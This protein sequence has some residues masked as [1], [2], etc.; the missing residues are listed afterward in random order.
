MRC[1]EHFCGQTLWIFSCGIRIFQY[2]LFPSINTVAS[3]LNHS[4]QAKCAVLEPLCAP[5]PTSVK[6]LAHHCILPGQYLA[7][8]CTLDAL[9]FI[10]LCT[11]VR[12]REDMLDSEVGAQPSNETTSKKLQ[13]L[14][15]A[16]FYN[17]ESMEENLRLECGCLRHRPK[18]KVLEHF[19]LR[20]LLKVTCQLN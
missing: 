13:I 15:N 6:Y 19:S 18:Y 2:H 4:I 11:G 5:M 14:Y 1:M 9:Q 10:L 7:F 16:I 17:N 12:G 20:S 3:C 8:Q